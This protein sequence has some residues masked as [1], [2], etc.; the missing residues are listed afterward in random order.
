MKRAFENLLRAN[1]Q[2]YCGILWVFYV[3]FSANGSSESKYALFYLW[4]KP[5]SIFYL[6]RLKSEASIYCLRISSSYL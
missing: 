4:I 2:I 5:L 1:V 3:I 6:P